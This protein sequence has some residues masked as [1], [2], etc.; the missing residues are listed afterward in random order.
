MSLLS[1]I[2]L[3]RVLCNRIIHLMQETIAS[4]LSIK[5]TTILSNDYRPRK[6][7]SDICSRWPDRNRDRPKLSRI[8]LT[9]SPR[10]SILSRLSC[11]LSR[12]FRLCTTAESTLFQVEPC[13]RLSV[14]SAP[15]LRPPL[16]TLHRQDNHRRQEMHR[17]TVIHQVR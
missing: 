6:V 15:S 1:V 11:F 7:Q 3:S 8:K 4:V 5:T 16:L 10:L 12:V 9:G 2:L 14:S 17:L 13:F